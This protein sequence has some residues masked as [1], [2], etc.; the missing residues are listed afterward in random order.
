VQNHVVH[1]DGESSSPSRVRSG[2]FVTIRPAHVMTHDNTY[3]VL[4][5]FHQS[6]GVTSM[7]DPSQPVFALDH[8]VQDRSKR[9]LNR[10]AAI[11]GFARKHGID[12]Y[13][14]G[15]GIGHQ[16]GHG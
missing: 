9:N 10:Y 16:V 11:E 15:R 4:S 5:K 1:S 8:N 2:D 13:P 6:L 3:A 7:A 12:F 14:A